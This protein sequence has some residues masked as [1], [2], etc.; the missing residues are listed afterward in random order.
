MALADPTGQIAHDALSDLPDPTDE[1]LW[2]KPDANE[3][4]AELRTLIENAGESRAATKLREL[5]DVAEAVY[6]RLYGDAER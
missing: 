4:I 5:L 1:D 6:A 3:M 2:M